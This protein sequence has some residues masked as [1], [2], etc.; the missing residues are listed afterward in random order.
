MVWRMND[1]YTCAQ[2]N[3]L[4]KATDIVSEPNEMH[5][6]CSEV[7][8]KSRNLRPV[9]Q[10]SKRLVTT[11]LLLVGKLPAPQH[12]RRRM[13]KRQHSGAASTKNG[14]KGVG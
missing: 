12:R 1:A 5:Q 11:V 8:A 3:D 10:G 13:T 7:V 14:M 2:L 9:G 6:I 4:R